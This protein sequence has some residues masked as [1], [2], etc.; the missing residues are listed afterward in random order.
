M[1]KVTD[2][3]FIEAWQKLGS[4]SLV[5]ENLKICESAVVQRRRKLKAHGINLESWNDLSSRRK[6]VKHSE[7]RVD[8]S[9]D[10]GTVI[11]FSDA[12]YWPDTRTTAHRALVSLIKQLKP[13]AVICNGDA[14]DGGTISR[15]PRI[16]W[17]KKPS[18]IEELCAVQ[19][20]LDGCALRDETGGV[21]S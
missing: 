19:K 17:D 14:F 15:Y 4:L 9:I 20:A 21:C 1:G 16:G 18:V 11:V 8:L 5:A 6:V 10:D 12:H 13:K 2:E 7:G 3:Q